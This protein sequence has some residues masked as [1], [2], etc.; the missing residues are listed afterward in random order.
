[1]KQQPTTVDFYI[2]SFPEYT[3]EILV[4]I[5]QIVL[6]NAPQAAEQISYGMPGYKTLGKPLVYFAGY[7]NHIGFYATPTGHKKFI[8]K[9]SP[10]K[11]GKGSVRFPLNQPIP[12]P[13]IAE[14]VKFRVIENER[15][16]K[17]AEK[18]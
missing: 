9:L 18:K 17:H 5:R 8:K 10:Y 7:K 11:Q 6:E 16:N 12:Y 15:K 2:S 3:Q 4:K 14:I 13:L 1:M